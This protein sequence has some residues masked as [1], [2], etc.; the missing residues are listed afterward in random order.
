MME[1]VK[2]ALCSACIVPYL[3][4]AV[5]QRTINDLLL[6]DSFDG[7]V[8]A[9]SSLMEQAKEM[10]I[11]DDVASLASSSGE[12]E[13]SEANEV[14][15]GS[16]EAKAQALINEAA[17]GLIALQDQETSEKGSTSS[18]SIE[19]AIQSSDTVFDFEFDIVYEQDAL[20]EAQSD[21]EQ[22]LDI[23]SQIDDANA[24]VYE[25]A[26]TLPVVDLIVDMEDDSSGIGYENYELVFYEP[27]PLEA[28]GDIDGDGAASILDIMELMTTLI[29]VDEA[30]SSLLDDEDGRLSIGEMSTSLNKP[31]HKMDVSGDNYVDVIDLMALAEIITS[32]VVVVDGF[33]Y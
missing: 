1:A 14:I 10:P 19:E 7:S 24:I 33:D 3:G 32:D 25:Y 2:L 11:T 5:A 13:E 28:R 29:A 9:L 4:V 31:C 21:L 18:I 12:A 8:E 15:S 22:V 17:N 20:R 23:V 27:V 26:V 16:E 6:S 30:M